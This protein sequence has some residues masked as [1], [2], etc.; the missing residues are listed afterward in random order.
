MV[1]RQEAG[2]RDP[3]RRRQ[4]NSD[5]D[6]RLRTRNTKKSQVVLFFFLNIMGREGKNGSTINCEK[7]DRIL[8]VKH[9]GM[10]RDY[11]GNSKE[12]G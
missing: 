2:V 9:F 3:L 7:K 10:L 1:P 8:G 12:C 4:V 6:R 11:E 5:S